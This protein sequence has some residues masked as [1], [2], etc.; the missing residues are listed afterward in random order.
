MSFLGIDFIILSSLWLIVVFTFMFIF[1]KKIFSFYYK[2]NDFELFILTLK[3]YLRKTYPNF[4]FNF[5]Y[6]EKLENEPNP[7]AKQYSL[8][9]NIINQYQTKK[10]TPNKTS[11]VPNNKLWSSYVLNSKPFKNKLPED[12]I[13]RKALV[14]QRDN[15]ICK[16]CSKTIGIKDSNIFMINSLENKGQYYIENLILFCLD[17]EKI[18]NQKRD[19]TKTIKHLDIKDELYS[20]VK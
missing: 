18:E 3:K 6:V 8:I 16:R 5:S 4:N 2:S 9:D 11:T 12:W 1:R 10:F 13:K 14:H 20:L 17:C 7:Q 19:E 15:K